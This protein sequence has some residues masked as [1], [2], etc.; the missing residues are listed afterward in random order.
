[1]LRSKAPVSP[2]NRPLPGI[3]LSY[4]Y[5]ADFE[6][7]KASTAIQKA[8]QLEPD[9]VLALVNLARLQFGSDDIDAAWQTLQRALVLAPD[10]AEV[11][12]LHGFSVIGAAGYRCRNK[13]FPTSYRTQPTLRRTASGFGFSVY[14]SRQRK[15]THCDQS[16]RRYCWN[17]KRSLFMSYWAKM[18]YQLKRFDKALDILDLA[19][20]YD[21]QDPT[22]L[23][24]EGL[25]LRDLN[26]PS[27]AIQTI[28]KAIQLNDRRAVY[29][30]RFLLDRDLAVK[31]SDLSILYRQLGL[32]A[33]AKSKAIASIKQDYTNASAHTFLAGVLSEQ[34]DRTGPLTSEAL[35]GR[36]LQPGSVNSFNSYN[37]Y[38][39]L[40]E[41]PAVNGDFSLTA[42]TDDR[43]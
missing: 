13:R 16:R 6:L 33:W 32:N 18:L 8:L 27:E 11:H 24:Y 26:R 19:K 12:N 41:Q 42:G 10:E 2:P 34:D 35:L 40:L 38:T 22:P 29:R 25:I 28:N 17:H 7:A 3:T 36:L 5:Q 30:S 15:T 39:T 43:P 31:N 20:Q 23:L 14:A 21:P 4:A 9:N 37:D 1:M